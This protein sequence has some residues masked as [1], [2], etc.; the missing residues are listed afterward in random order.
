MIN[1]K[2]VRDRRVLR[3]ESIDDVL[4]DAEMLVEAARGG[5]L[6]GTGNRT[7]GQGLAHLAA[8]VKMPFDG[9]PEMPRPAW[10][11]RLLRPVITKWIVHK[12]FP[13]GVR[14]AGVEGG[15]FGIEPCEMEEGLGRLRSAFGRLA[16]EV[17][18]Q[19]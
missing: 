15:T 3:F 11:M 10:W 4:R 12:G 2:R 6:L 8:W 16:A 18:M 7:L 19:T 9:Y 1:T 5:T 17:P 13:A 14:I